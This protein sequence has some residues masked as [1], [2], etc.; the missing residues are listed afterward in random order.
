MDEKNVRIVTLE[1]LRVASIWGFGEQ[2]ELTAFAK[3]NEWAGPLG[4]R[5]DPNRFR[6]FGF[7]N[8][9][10]HPGSP[11]YGYE[12]WLEVGPEIEAEGDV[13]IKEFRGG[14]Y[15]VALCRVSEGEY[16]VI[17]E[18]WQR[19]AGWREDSKYEMGQHQWLERHLPPD[20]PGI[21]FILELYLPIAE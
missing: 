7:N 14:K 15:A 21:E 6:L 20:A 9:D 12:L 4:L 8:P 1:P 13:K 18:S 19:L 16:G 10:P 2:P 11:N 3:L 17:G 5:D